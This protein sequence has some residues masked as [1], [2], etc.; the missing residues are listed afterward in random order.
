MRYLLS[1][2]LGF[3]RSNGEI[4]RWQKS[5]PSCQLC[6]KFGFL[7]ILLGIESEITSASHS[8]NQKTFFPDIGTWSIKTALERFT[9]WYSFIYPWNLTRKYVKEKTSSFQT[10][11]W[12]TSHSLYLSIIFDLCYFVLGNKI[13]SILFSVKSSQHLVLWKRLLQHVTLFSLKMLAKG[14]FSVGLGP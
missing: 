5:S 8:I 10:F 9:V 12:V 2:S 6:F 14:L 7:C 4:M 11:S 3:S 1:R 13:K